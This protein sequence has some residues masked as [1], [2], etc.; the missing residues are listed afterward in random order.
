V[1]VGFINVTNRIDGF[2][3]GFINIADNGFFPVFP[4]FN[5]PSD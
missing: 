5:F 4:I 2:Q 1:Q 3:F